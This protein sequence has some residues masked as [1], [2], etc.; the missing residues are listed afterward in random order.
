MKV[1]EVLLYGLV[2][3]EKVGGKVSAFEVEFPSDH[4]FFPM[5]Y[6]FLLEVVFEKGDLLDLPV[7]LYLAGHLVDG[8]ELILAVVEVGDAS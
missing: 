8:V 3:G 6:N 1:V 4:H 5:H 2:L 7:V